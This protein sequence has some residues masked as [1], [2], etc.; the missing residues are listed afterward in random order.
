MS[1]RLSYCGPRWR[2]NT[3][4]C[5]VAAA[6]ALGCLWLC[7]VAAPQIAWTADAPDWLRAQLSAPLPAH[8]DKTDAVKMYAETVFTAQADGRLK[9]LERGAYRIL[10]PEGG[11][12]GLVR[13]PFDAM[14]RVTALHGWSIPAEGKVFEVKEK[15]SFES[16]VFGVDN[17]VLVSDTQMKVLQ[18]PAALPGN[19]VGYE[20]EQEIRPYMAGDTWDFQ[21]TV[22][23]R[24][25]HYTL[26]LPPGW[27]YRADWINAAPTAAVA[28]G[29]GRWTWTVSNV[30]AV[31]PE[32]DMPPWQGI[33]GRMA[34]SL[35]PPAGAAPGIRN[36]SDLGL[37]YYN[38]ARDRGTATPEIQARTGALTDA[39][40]TMLA[41]MQ[42][43][44]QF[45]QNDI[46][47]VAIQL[48]IGGH[49]PHAA[50][51][52]LSNRFGDCKDKATLLGAMLKVLGIDSYHVVINTTR[53]SISSAM[54]PH[55]GFNHMILA[56]ALPAGLKDPS[57]L[58]TYQIPKLG[59]L[60]FF[61]PT[62]NLTPFGSIRGDLQANVALLTTP[63]GGELVTLPQLP[64]ETSGVQRTAKTTLDAQGVLRGEFHE[65][66][67]GD[68]ASRQ[69]DELRSSTLDTDRIK[70][71]EAV[72]AASLTTYSLLRATIANLQNT[73][74]PF[75]WNYSLE[76]QNYAKVSGGLMLVRPRILG[77][78]SSA[79][80]ETEEPRRYPVEF[81][82]P[83]R[84]SDDFEI[85]LPAGFEVDDL[86][87]PVNLDY[88]FASYQSHTSVTGRVLHYHR[89]FE[90]RQ[91]SVPV[92]KSADLKRLY[93]EIA[94]DERQMAVLKSSSP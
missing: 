79:L 11:E 83:H 14:S 45:V 1:S 17:S 91:L 37:W 47:Y 73:A 38:L 85:A 25:A 67:T 34:L 7:M 53:G 50:G 35:Y 52:V 16:A 61:D 4:R 27:D 39:A 72:A 78:K 41:K 65:T 43:L 23:V 76:A 75:E 87:E 48:G 66:R 51:T 22:P 32:P 26:Q 3:E 21:E 30:E 93:R 36:W 77:N 28:S 24:E 8:D 10:R 68:A 6:P 64:S 44:A 31:R 57:L 82:G 20:I 74:K 42:A 80:L 63:D 18:L 46:R 15:N 60:L 49:Q 84:D 12:R 94:G 19:L 54:P 86:P 71:V 70:P 5:G 89:T 2:P 92:A 9:V 29:N 58:A 81:D 13:V 69:R 56:I 59:R 90:I 55:L 40:P 62:D 88:G 33:A